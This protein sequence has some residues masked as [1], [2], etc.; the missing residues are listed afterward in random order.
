MAKHQVAADVHILSAV[1][2]AVDLISAEATP[3]KM[4]KEDK[5]IVKTSL[6][7]SSF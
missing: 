3:I 5:A 2:P 1:K 6:I 4:I 7:L